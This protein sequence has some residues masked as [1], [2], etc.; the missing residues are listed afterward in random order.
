MARTSAMHLWLIGV[1][2]STA[3]LNACSEKHLDTADN[4]SN[5]VFKTV[6]AHIAGADAFTPAQ[7]R[8]WTK[9][10]REAQQRWIAFSDQDCGELIGFEWDGATGMT[11]ARYAAAECQS[12]RPAARNS[13][14]A[15]H[16]GN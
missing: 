2:G 11:G 6:F 15:I 10:M 16:Q 9:A 3:E 13:K 14:S 12:P 4:N 5:T 1:V 7:R 8:D